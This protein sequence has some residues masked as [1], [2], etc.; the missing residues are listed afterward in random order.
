MWSEPTFAQ[1]Q[2]IVDLI[3]KQ[4][5][6][7]CVLVS[8][9][10]GGLVIM[11]L[12]L[13]LL[14]LLFPLIILHLHILLLQVATHSLLLSLH[15]SLLAT[16]LKEHVWR[17]GVTLPLA[18]PAIKGLVSL[19]HGQGAVRGVK[20]QEVKEAADLLAIPWHGLRG[21]SDVHLGHVKV[22]PEDDLNC[23]QVNMNSL[24]RNFPNSLITKDIV[25][26]GQ[27][28]RPKVAKIKTRLE[29]A[30]KY[31]GFN[32]N[33]DCFDSGSVKE[34]NKPY[35]VDK[36][37]KSEHA[38]NARKAKRK[39]SRSAPK[40]FLCDEC[41]IGFSSNRFLMR[42]K[43]KAHNINMKCE[44]CTEEFSAYHLFKKHFMENHPSFTCPVCGIARFNKT[45][46]GTHME[47]QHETNI[48]CPQCGVMYTTKTSLNLHIGRIHSDKELQKCPKC[49]YKTRMTYEVRGH[50][51]RMHTENNKETCQYCGEVFKN[52]KK[53]LLRTGCDGKVVERK[54]LPCNQCDKEFAWKSILAKHVKEIHSGIKD[55]ACPN[56]SY[57]TYSGSNLKLH[58]SKMHFGTKIVKLICPHCEKPTT[59]IKHHTNIYHPLLSDNSTIYKG[60]P[61]K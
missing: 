30:V 43:L 2:D 3:H 19:L 6:Q 20:E 23:V 35:F 37:I 12:L 52:L 38:R 46:L 61:T 53:H 22:N 11:L 50:F 39:L 48:P 25:S 32:A 14:L 16:L 26:D 58:I 60:R 56:C 40:D 49:D 17:Q 8:S 33:A 29:P 7:D 18:L 4:G 21:N 28:K 1:A 15:S 5:E 27:N 41:R 45:S 10:C 51:M 55:R 59:N 47:S 36:D 54:K 9:H 44:K 34:E 24:K 13:L 42:H 31:E 57:A